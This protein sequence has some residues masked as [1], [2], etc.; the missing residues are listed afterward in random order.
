MTSELRELQASAEVLA[1]DCRDAGLWQA[2]AMAEA[3]GHFIR[4]EIQARESTER[5][6]SNGK[7][8]S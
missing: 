6:T 5:G 7:S 1:T 4:K 2:A 3:A 8:G